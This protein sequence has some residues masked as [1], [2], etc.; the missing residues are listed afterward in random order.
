MWQKKKYSSCGRCLELCWPGVRESR[1]SKHSRWPAPSTQGKMN[2]NHMLNCICHLLIVFWGHGVALNING[3]AISVRLL[4]QLL[5]SNMFY[6]LLSSHTLHWRTK[7]TCVCL[8]FFP[9]VS[10]HFHIASFP[11]FSFSSWK[12]RKNKPSHQ[13][14]MTIYSWG[15]NPVGVWKLTLSYICLIYASIDE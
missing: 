9:G 11:V 3:S 10:F 8:V 4:K 7:S 2:N 12:R 14:I 6:W 13:T 15:E 1:W 5:G